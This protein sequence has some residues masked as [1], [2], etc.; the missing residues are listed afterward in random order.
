[1]AVVRRTFALACVVGFLGWC[2]DAKGQGADVLYSEINGLQNYGSIDGIRAYSLRSVTCNIGDQAMLWQNRGTPGFGSNAYRLYEGRL[3]QIGMSWVKHACCAFDTFG[4]GPTC[5]ASSGGVGAGCQDVYSAGFNGSFTWLGSRSGIN[6]FTG[7]FSPIDGQTGPATFRRLQVRESDMDAANFPGALY[8]LEGVYVGSDDALSGNAMNNA[9]YK[10]VTVA[11]SNFDFSE[12]EGLNAGLPAIY[13]WQAH[14]N[15]VNQPDPSIEIREVDVTNEGRFHAASRATDNGDGTWRY[16]YAVFNLNS[17]RSG[18]SL[19]VP[20]G[21]GVTVTNVGF[22]D[23]DYHSGDPYDN[24]DWSSSVTS[25]AV[26]WNS[27][28]TFKQNENSNALRWGTMYTFWFDADTGPAET[29]ITLGLFRPGTPS[30]VSFEGVAP[31]LACAAPNFVGGE[32]GVSF[33]QRA[34]DGFIDARAESTDGQSVD[35]GLSAFTF[36]FTTPVE[37]LDGTSIDASAFSIS[38]TGGSPPSITDVQTEDGVS[39]TVVLDGNIS[40]GEWTTITASVRAQC[41][42]SLTFNE[43]IRVGYLPADIDQS[44]SVSPQDLFQFRQLVNEIIEPNIGTEADVLDIS[45][46][47]NVNPLDLLLLRQLIN[48]V[49]QS[50]QPWAGA[51]LPE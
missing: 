10:R 44:G 18:G 19:S 29:D 34:Y 8:F 20:I 43:S 45:R 17:H 22:N 36:E 37:N 9:S 47:G 16:T 28:E 32:A 5:Q 14:A 21:A 41:D 11:N 13:A 48:G 1:M 33:A 46:D 30:S 12:V 23:V 49:G 40:L 4:C 31:E 26:T 39:V 25:N 6:A 50:T 51:S 42:A 35:L 27:P 38:D 7:T 24:T 15:G 2:G 3:E